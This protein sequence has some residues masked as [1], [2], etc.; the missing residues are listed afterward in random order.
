MPDAKPAY[1]VD[2]CQYW[3][4]KAAVD[5]CMV[6]FDEKGKIYGYFRQLWLIRSSIL[7]ALNQI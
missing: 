4:F 2:I 3:Q 5:V 7:P 6:I 1:T